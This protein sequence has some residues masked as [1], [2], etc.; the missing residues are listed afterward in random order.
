MKT[1]MEATYFSE[2]LVDFQPITW[3]HTPEYG[4]LDYIVFAII[5]KAL[6]G[7][8]YSF[9]V[10]LVSCSNSD[11]D[12]HCFLFVYGLVSFCLTP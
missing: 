10:S 9:Q 12:I 11:L 1:A 3:C 4:V 8:S 7:A 2:T 5:A 6:I